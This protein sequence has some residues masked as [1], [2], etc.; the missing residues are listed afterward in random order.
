VLMTLN[1]PDG[2]YEKIYDGYRVHYELPNYVLTEKKVF[3][4]PTWWTIFEL[5]YECSPEIWGRDVSM[6]LKNTRYWNADY[7]VHYQ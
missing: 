2:V 6:I 5:N 1:N 3:M 4:L 7:I